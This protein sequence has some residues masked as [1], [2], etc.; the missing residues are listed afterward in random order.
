LLGRLDHSDSF[1]RASLSKDVG[2]I[3]FMNTSLSGQDA[4]HW[5][6]IST[7]LWKHAEAL[8]NDRADRSR[9]AV[10]KRKP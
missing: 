3:V 9:K 2:V 1:L 7:E 8:K 5:A 4:K 6:A 10:E